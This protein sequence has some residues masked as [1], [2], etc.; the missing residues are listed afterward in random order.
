MADITS[1]NPPKPTDPTEEPQHLNYRITRIDGSIIEATGY[2]VMTSGLFAVCR[3]DFVRYVA[4][5]N[6]IVEAVEIP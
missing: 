1:I 6:Q 5:W 3:N 2:T 4:P